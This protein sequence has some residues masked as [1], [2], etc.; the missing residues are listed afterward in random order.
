MPCTA[1]L[2][3]LLHTDEGLLKHL[4][5]LIHLL[6]HPEWISTWQHVVGRCLDSQMQR[7]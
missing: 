4:V 2:L 5:H 1:H 6:K 7:K 3:L